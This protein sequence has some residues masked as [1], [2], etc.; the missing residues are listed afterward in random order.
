VDAASV[1]RLIVL[2]AIWGG[3]FLFM[4]IAAPVLGT[5]V[6]A[7]VR[8]ILASLF[9]LIV[10]WAL[11]RPLD[12]RRHWKHFLILGLVNSALPFLLFSFAAQTLSASVMSILN[13]TAPIWGAIIGALWTRR[14]PSGP[15]ALGLLLGVAGVALLVGTD[16]LTLQPGAAAAIAAAL[17]GALSYGIATNYAKSA[18]A[19]EPFANALGS[20]WAA[21]ILV[22]PAIPFAPPVA[23]PGAGVMA[24]A[25][26]LGIVCSGMAYL[27]Y[28]RLVK[29]MG[30][31]SA[32]TVTFLIPVF[33]VLW[34]NLFL[35]EAVRWNTIVGAGIIIVGTALATNFNLL[36]LMR[37]RAGRR[38]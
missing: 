15:T 23:S 2:S 17:L 29:D 31:T 4:R 3:S 32:L 27:L 12:A 16:Q 9:L 28:F 30:A 34:G 35:S 21:A 11:R 25:A 1:I 36:A 20:M 10:G 22:A 19:V 8:G 24:A 18:T 13:A 7:E 26:A 5:V 14:V 38:A 37:Q 6:L 33:G